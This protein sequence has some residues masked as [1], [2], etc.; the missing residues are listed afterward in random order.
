[1]EFDDGVSESVAPFHLGHTLVT[2]SDK[3][4]DFMEQ[5][6]PRQAGTAVSLLRLRLS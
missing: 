4:P 3:L 1:V 5:P 2:L 6:S